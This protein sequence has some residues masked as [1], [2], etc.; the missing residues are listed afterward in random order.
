MR[1][2]ILSIAALL[3][4]LLACQAD[5]P[6][7]PGGQGQPRFQL[8]SAS[9]SGIDFQNQI[10]ETA[11]DNVLAYEYFY[12]GGGVAAAD[13]NQD[14]RIDLYFTANMLPNKLYLNKGNWAF[15]DITGTAGVAGR[16]DGWSTGV[17]IVDINADGLPDIYLCYSG[18]KA[19]ALRR[20]ELYINQGPDADG[21]PTFIESAAQYQLDIPAYTTQALFFDYD[22]DGDLDCYLLNHSIEDFQNFDA[23]YVK[24]QQDPFAGDQLLRNDNGV[25]TNVST[26]AGINSSPLGF[27]L[28]IA[29]SDVNGDGFLDLYVS[30]DYIEQD[31]LYINQGDG[32]FREA[33]QEQMGHISH[34]SMGSAVADYNNDLLP[35]ILTLDMLPEDNQRQKLLYGPDT[36]EKYQSMLR[37]GFFHQVM[38]NML[39]R[40]NGDGTFSEIG[41]LAGISNTDWSWAALLEDFDNDGWKDL[42]ITNGYLRDYTNRDFVD[43]YADQRIKEQRGE[44]ADGLL[45]IIAKMESTKT[46]NYFFRNQRDLTF[47]D[48]SQAAGFG[49][50]LLSNGAIAADLDND[51]DLDLVLNNLNAPAHLY[52]NTSA[53]PA[54][55]YLQIQL[56]MPGQNRHAIGAKVILKTGTQ[57]MMQEFIPS[58]GFQSAAHTPLHFGLGDVST[59]DTLLVLWPNG[60]QSIQIGVAANQQLKIGSETAVEKP[61]APA[62]KPIFSPIPSPVPIAHLERGNAD[63]KQ[64]TLLPYGVSGLGPAVAQADVNGD[65]LEDVFVGGAKLQ[66]AQLY[67]QQKDGRLQLSEQGAIQKDLVM[68]DVVAHF[69][70]AN[71]D[72]HPDLYVGSGGYQ[73]LAEDLALQDRLYLNDGAGNFSRAP[74]AL[75]VMR[76]STAKVAVADIDGDDDLDIF[77]A[78]RLVPGQ[79]P[80]SP[81]SYLLINDGQGNFSDQTNERAAALRQA[82]MLTAALWLDVNQDNT[83]D[84]ITAGEWEPLRCFLNKNGV[85]EEAPNFFGQDTEGWWWSLATADLDGDGDLDLIAGNL[86]EN[87]SWKVRP[88]EPAR[89][90]FGDFD[91][92]GAIDPLMTHYIQGKEYPSMSRD[93]LFGQLAGMRKKFT[94]YASFA[95]AKITDILPPEQLAGA[96]LLQA[97]TGQS[98]WIENRGKAAW[99]IHPLPKIAQAA[100]IFAILPTDVDGDGSTDLILAGNLSETR[101]NMGPWDANYGQ[102]FL[103]DGQGNF[104]YVPQSKSGLSLIGDVRSVIQLKDARGKRLLFMRNNRLPLAY[105]Y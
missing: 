26:A 99:V 56:E 84:L 44:A 70:D 53:S 16:A 30:N 47:Q 54:A 22:R 35:D 4:C 76:S 92:N 93:N 67:L 100:P 14:G 5:K 7:S 23:S 6:D 37:N 77:V 78:S 104:S 57:Q 21:I 87:A 68:E 63:F 94:N 73:F 39:Q 24:N 38:R 72:G 79:Y 50:A 61:V 18:N 66:A 74:A 82:G 71:G 17:T 11:T 32:T 65:G 49:E 86:G 83:P 60:Q 36:Y 101:A 31:Y 75:P 58:R 29:A 105:R 15:E 45:D 19:E 52:E 81:N 28:G 8:R 98:V 13:F 62:T 90:Y 41:Q 91:G 48:Q 33:L 9:T 46:H 42:F 10:T 1:Y 88:E 3:C 12:N 51:G 103:N 27:G 25:F 80:V 95:D 2:R 34:F 85:L 40:N 102:L 96:Q 64:Q 97:K 55:S 43:Y 59:V 20:N 89:L 69:F